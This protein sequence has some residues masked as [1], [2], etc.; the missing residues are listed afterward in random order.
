MKQS[1]FFFAQFWKEGRKITKTLSLSHPFIILTFCLFFFSSL[2]T[3]VKVSTQT[4]VQCLMELFQCLIIICPHHKTI[5]SQSVIISLYC[6]AKAAGC[7]GYTWST[8]WAGRVRKHRN[9]LHEA[10]LRL[11]VLLAFLERKKK[12]GT[13]STQTLRG[14][15]TLLTYFLPAVY[16]CKLFFA[17]EKN[18]GHI[19]LRLYLINFSY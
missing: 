19:M 1:F 14:A 16:G 12:K 11:G 2:E 6:L 15:I 7:I 9:C 17:L 3:R 8:C 4:Q 5:I 13:N 18:Q 10:D